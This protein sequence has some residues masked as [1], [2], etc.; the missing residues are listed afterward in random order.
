MDY[1]YLSKEK[2][3]AIGEPSERGRDVLKYSDQCL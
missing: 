2:E 3:K 1:G